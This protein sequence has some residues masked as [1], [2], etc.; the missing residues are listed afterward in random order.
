MFPFYYVDCRGDLWVP[1]DC[2]TG[3]MGTT[4]ATGSTGSTGSTGAAGETGSTGAVEN[5]GAIGEAGTDPGDDTRLQDDIMV[6]KA[7]MREVLGAVKHLEDEV[8]S[9][10]AEE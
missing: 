1:C 2:A 6:L 9:L 8:E 7:L 4:W 10:K 5:T 3:T